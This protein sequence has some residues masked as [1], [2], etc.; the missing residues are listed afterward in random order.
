MEHLQLLE[1]IGETKTD[2]LIQDCYKIYRESFDKLFPDYFDKNLVKAISF[3]TIQD[4]DSNE[5]KQIG[6]SCIDDLLTKQFAQWF[7]GIIG[8]NNGAFP[9]PVKS[10]AGN[11]FPIGFSHGGSNFSRW[12]NTANAGQN[13]GMRLQWGNGSDAILKDSFN[14]SSMIQSLVI[15]NGGTFV[16]GLGQVT[17]SGSAVILV[18]DTIKQT[19]ILGIFADTSQN[20][21]NYLLA[22]DNINPNVPVLIAQLLNIE[23]KLVFS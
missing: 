22:W 4:K 16:S 1:K 21:N 2:K 12:G 13:R 5:I 7:S 10:T 19:S 11:L 14:P 17:W 6:M 9:E 8:G 18:N 15:P 23:Y 3:V 20:N